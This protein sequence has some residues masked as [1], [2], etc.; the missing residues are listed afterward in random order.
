MGVLIKH[1]KYFKSIHNKSIILY[2]R[3]IRV[4]ANVYFNHNFDILPHKYV[5]SSFIK[6]IIIIVFLLLSTNHFTYLEIC[7]I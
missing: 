5:V 2:Y 3:C 7:K 1:L 4:N 6:D